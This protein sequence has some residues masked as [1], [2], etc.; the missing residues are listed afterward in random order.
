MNL[1]AVNKNNRLKTRIPKDNMQRFGS[2]KC[3]TGAV[4]AGDFGNGAGCYNAITYSWV[5]EMCHGPYGW[6]Y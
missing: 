6:W 1:K 4:I 2:C 3:Y 5:G